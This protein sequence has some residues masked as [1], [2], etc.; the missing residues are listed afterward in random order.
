[1]ILK[2]KP[3]RVMFRTIFFIQ[4]YLTTINNIWIWHALNEWIE[5]ILWTKMDKKASGINK[6]ISRATIFGQNTDITL[7]QI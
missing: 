4:I 6:L 7:N 1:M 3:T 5:L 2:K